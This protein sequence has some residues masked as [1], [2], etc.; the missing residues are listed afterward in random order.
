MLSLVTEALARQARSGCNP[1]R[2]TALLPTHTHIHAH[3]TYGPVLFVDSCACCVSVSVCV[4]VHGVSN[5][6]CGRGTAGRGP[7][8]KQTERGR[9]RFHWCTW[10]CVHTHIYRAASITECVLRQTGN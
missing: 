7:I 3:P 4:C 1:A 6:V 8:E 5:P 10:R 2:D 9:A